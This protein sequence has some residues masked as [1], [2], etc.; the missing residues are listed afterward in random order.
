[1]ISKKILES[2]IEFKDLMGSMLGNT[3]SYSEEE[4]D[5]DDFN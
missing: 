5:S 4:F 3:T 2:R 1:M